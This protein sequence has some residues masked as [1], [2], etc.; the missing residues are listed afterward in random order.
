MTDKSQGRPFFRSKCAILKLV[1]NDPTA[2]GFQNT[3]KTKQNRMLKKISS[4]LNNI[5][6]KPKHNIDSNAS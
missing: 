3:I 6:A 5:H 1:F 2:A 4:M